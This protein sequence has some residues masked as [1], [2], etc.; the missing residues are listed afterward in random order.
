MIPTLTFLG[1]LILSA[2]CLLFLWRS[3][4][5]LSPTEAALVLRSGTPSRIVFGDFVLMPFFE[6]LERISLQEQH[7]SFSFRN[8]ESIHTANGQ[9]LNIEVEITLS[10]PRDRK[11]IKRLLDEKGLDVFTNSDILKRELAPLV[12][13]S[14]PTVLK[15]KNAQ[16]WINHE[17]TEIMRAIEKRCQQADIGFDIKSIVISSLRSTDQEFYNPQSIEDKKGLLSFHEETSSLEEIEQERA[18]IIARKEALEE[19]RKDLQ[20]RLLEIQSETNEVDKQYSIFQTHLEHIRQEIRVQID[21]L[22]SHL[23]VELSDYRREAAQ[24]SALL[25]KNPPKSVGRE[26]S[27]LRNRHRIDAD[28]LKREQELQIDTIENRVQKEKE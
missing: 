4:I 2:F 23:D 15:N 12:N 25:G 17:R 9:K 8:E 28:M 5:S 26:S 20:H 10:P 11:K 16:D 1:G 7:H 18:R 22:K 13:E 21:L 3:R 14:L 19:E 27:K 6:R 24:E